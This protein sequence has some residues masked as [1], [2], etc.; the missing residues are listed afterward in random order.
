MG[1]MGAKDEFVITVP[2]GIDHSIFWNTKDY[3]I[4]ELILYPNLMVA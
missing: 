3:T 1:A 2:W 4:H